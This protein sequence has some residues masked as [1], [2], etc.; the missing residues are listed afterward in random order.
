MKLARILFI[1]KNKFVEIEIV[2][3]KYTCFLSASIRIDSPN[4][5]PQKRCHHELAP[6]A[7]TN[8]R[9]FGLDSLLIGV[10]TQMLTAKYNVLLVRLLPKRRIT[11]KKLT[12]NIYSITMYIEKRSRATSHM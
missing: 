12:E 5:E 2:L 1:Q 10:R 6:T 9:I 8:S 11:K 4:F 3:S 7:N